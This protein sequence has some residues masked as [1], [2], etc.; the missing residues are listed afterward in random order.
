MK[1][2][3]IHRASSLSYPQLRYV[4]VNI[5]VRC[6]YYRLTY[7]E[8]AQTSSSSVA[9]N[10]CIPTFRDFPRV[11]SDVLIHAR[12]TRAALPFGE[13]PHRPFVAIYMEGVRSALAERFCTRVG[14]QAC[15]KQSPRRRAD[16][17][18]RTARPPVKAATTAKVAA[19]AAPPSTI[20]HGRDDW[21]CRGEL[22]GRFG[23]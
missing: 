3:V 12:L 19:A 7:G 14:A 10:A 16:E 22:C 5:E 6:D 9:R 21:R 4:T 23:A 20:C 17:C 8:S 11:K 15:K 18:R 1:F 13:Q 2:Y